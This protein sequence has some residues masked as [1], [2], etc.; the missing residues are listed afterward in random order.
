MNIFLNPIY[1]LLYAQLTLCMDTVLLT[2]YKK[3]MVLTMQ[4]SLKMAVIKYV[5]CNIVMH[6]LSE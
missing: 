2:E 4:I 3:S 1:T 5:K 6:K